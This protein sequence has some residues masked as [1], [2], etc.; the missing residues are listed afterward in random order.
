M[1]RRIQCSLMVAAHTFK[2]MRLQKHASLKSL[3][4]TG[5]PLPQGKASDFEQAS[6]LDERQPS[7][8]CQA[9]EK[10]AGIKNLFKVWVSFGS[11]WPWTRSHAM[12]CI[13]WPLAGACSSLG[14]LHWA[15]GPSRCF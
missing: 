11:L 7:C 9:R 14:P 12:P 15:L 1:D 6:I 2:E 5:Y 10:K 8:I 4:L 13:G 3:S